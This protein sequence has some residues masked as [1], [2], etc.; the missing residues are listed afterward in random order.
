MGKPTLVISILIVI[1]VVGILFLR[2][3]NKAVPTTTS[4]KPTPSQV[5]TSPTM[6]QT[7]TTSS[8]PLTVTSPTETT[9]STQLI[10]ISG[11]TLPSADVFVNETQLKADPQGKFSTQVLLDEGENTIVITANDEN[12]NHVEKEITVSYMATTQ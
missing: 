6:T 1:V 5:I 2:T 9:V 11:Q 8:L 10:S 4:Y 7:P 3:T 12:G